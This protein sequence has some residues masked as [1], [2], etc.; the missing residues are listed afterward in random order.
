MKDAT[1]TAPYGSLWSN[2]VILV[3]TKEGDGSSRPGKYP[4]EGSMSQPTKMVELADPITYMRLHNEAVLTRNPDGEH[5]LIRN[6][7]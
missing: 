6:R 2:G 7:R 4:V 5:Y 3:T 1:A